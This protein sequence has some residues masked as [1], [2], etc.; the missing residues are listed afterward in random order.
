MLGASIGLRHCL[1][2]LSVPLIGP[3]G[4]PLLRPHRPRTV[5]D[6]VREFRLKLLIGDL[7]P[8]P[9]DR[10]SRLA[11]GADLVEMPH[12]EN[13]VNAAAHC[14]MRVIQQRQQLQQ[15]LAGRFVIGDLHARG[16]IAGQDGATWAEKTGATLPADGVT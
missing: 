13:R 1:T 11:R 6:G 9:S 5:S 4:E 8:S 12:Q 7:N 16:Q 15:S 14:F 10:C 2:D 3:F